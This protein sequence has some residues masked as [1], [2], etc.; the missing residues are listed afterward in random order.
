MYKKEPAC[1]KDSKKQAIVESRDIVAS[2]EAN[3]AIL[4]T[5]S[6]YTHLSKAESLRGYVVRLVR[7]CL[8]LSSGAKSSDFIANAGLSIINIHL[9][10]LSILMTFV[11]VPVFISLYYTE[12]WKMCR[13]TPTCKVFLIQAIEIH[14]PI[15]G[16]ALGVSRMARCNPRGSSGD[17]PVPCV[18]E[19][20]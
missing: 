11:A 3:S 1:T 4:E 10:I 15:K 8:D 19:K 12:R 2:A 20:A 6:D 13:F 17:D 16:F 14:G 9:N 5:E 7:A 18:H